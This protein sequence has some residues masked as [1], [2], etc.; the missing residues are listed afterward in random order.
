M[1]S[2]QA[3]LQN[4]TYIG[5]VWTDPLTITVRVHNTNVVTYRRDADTGHWYAKLQTGGYFT[6]LTLTR[7]NDFLPDNITVRGPLNKMG[8]MTHRQWWVNVDKST[9]S[10]VGVGDQELYS[11][12]EGIE[13]QVKAP[14][15]D[16]GPL[17]THDSAGQP[18]GA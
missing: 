4:N 13:V 1:S 18:G 14:N 5:M 10:M 12:Y 6:R 17:P 2:A 9:P 7:M 11:F 15:F 8:D 3:K 16:F